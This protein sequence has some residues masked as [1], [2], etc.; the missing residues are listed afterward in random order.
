MIFYLS[1]AILVLLSPVYLIRSARPLPPYTRRW[2]IFIFSALFITM[3]AASIH[4]SGFRFE[5]FLLL[6]FWL[7]IAYLALKGD[8]AALIHWTRIS[9]LLG[10]ALVVWFD[11]LGPADQAQGDWSNTALF[12]FVSTGLIWA[13][14][15]AERR[16]SRALEISAASI[17]TAEYTDP[18]QTEA[19]AKTIAEK[20]L[21]QIYLTDDNVGATAAVNPESQSAKPRTP[22]RREKNMNVEKKLVTICSVIW[23]FALTFVPTESC[24]AGKYGEI[25]MKWGW[26]F[27]W[28][29][30][31]D[32][33][34]DMSRI[35]LQLGVA[36]VVTVA[37]WYTMGR[38]KSD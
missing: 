13:R 21:D 18:D 7:Y 5:Y 27:I 16:K 28:S 23:I 30:G 14:L 22:T 38:K 26:D 36:A 29:M 19:H 17:D 31:W 8:A 15:S 3:F 34:V 10:G 4:S 6:A 12:V 25:C 35:T 37:L 24:G 32:N 2:G 9:C 1:I 11:Y 33:S 20:L